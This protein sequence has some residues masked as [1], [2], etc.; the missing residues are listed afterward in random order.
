MPPFDSTADLKHSLANGNVCAFVGAGLSVGAGLP[1]W[2]DL[3]SELAQRIDYK[4]LPPRQWAT[5]DALIDVAQAYVNGQGLHSLIAFLKDRLDTFNKTPTAAHRALVRLPIS[6][7]FTA[8][9]DDLLERAYR[10][11][12]KRVEV[13][14]KD[15]GIPFMRR[16]LDVVNI[17]KLY[18]DL[19]QPDTLVLAR[20]QYEAFFLER[21]QLIK[22]LETELA[23]SDVLYLGW[24]HT[25]PHFNLIFGE[26]LTRFGPFLRA[27]Y[28]TMFD[29]PTAK[30]Q[31][32]QRKQ[33]RLASLPTGP[34]RT[35]Q[36]AIWLESLAWGGVGAASTQARVFGDAAGA[37]VPPNAQSIPGQAGARQ[38]S[39]VKLRGVLASLYGD[40][41]SI[42]R[43]VAD[44]G[45]DE[46][47]IAFG[48]SA[49]NNWHAV[50]SEAEKRGQI[51]ALL[52]VALAD[53]APNPQL[54]EA[55]A[56]YQRRATD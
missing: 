45:L 33:I 47:Q 10:E 36:L 30:Q 4:E 26:L 13:V 16:G 40:E 48:H 37:S 24:S 11:A 8:N 17:I 20:Q 54:S 28:A 42:R 38:S 27:G 55:V 56:E 25:D 7:V 29:A 41:K 52:A 50:L 12:G 51:A 9:Y 44:A 6:L 1:G 22:L 3:I 21:P 23:R 15:S 43:V 18:G 32:L 46:R 14:V 49:V 2:Y 31:E 39:L 5:S 19:N 35:A 53:Y 34:D